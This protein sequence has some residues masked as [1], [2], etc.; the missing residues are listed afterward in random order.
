M[1]LTSRFVVYINFKELTPKM[2]HTK[3]QDNRPSDS[4]EED[5]LGFLSYMGMAAI[6][7]IRPEPNT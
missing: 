2:L 7:V 6:L 1:T 3:F 4:G 5:F